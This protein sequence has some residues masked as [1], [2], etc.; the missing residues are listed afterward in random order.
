MVRRSSR[1]CLGDN[2][3][4]AS[5]P[6]TARSLRNGARAR[7]LETESEPKQTR[8]KRNPLSCSLQGGRKAF[9]IRR[10]LGTHSPFPQVQVRLRD[11][12]QNAQSPPSRRYLWVCWSYFRILLRIRSG[13]GAVG[14]NCAIRVRTRGSGL[15]NDVA[16]SGAFGNSGHPF[17]ELLMGFELFSGLTSRFCAFRSASR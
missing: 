10:R 15:R 9:K 3:R 12:L 7:V 17:R 13:P 16:L 6:L 5:I 2:A 14:S 8:M 11:V 1:S 4:V